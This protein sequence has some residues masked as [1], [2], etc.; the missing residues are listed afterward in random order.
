MSLVLGFFRSRFGELAEALG[1]LSRLPLGRFAP[2]APPSARV[3]W[4]FPLVGVILGGLAGGVDLL[5]A[6]LGLSPWLAAAWA[7]AVG[8]LLSGALHEDG[9]ADAADGLGAEGSAARRLAVMR[10]PRA[11]NYAVL[12]LILSV[13]IRLAALAAITPAGAA[14]KALMVAG[15]GGRTAMI[16][17]PLLLPP[18]RASGLGAALG[19]PGKGVALA[20]FARGLGLLATLLSPARLCAVVLAAGLGLGVVALA[21]KWRLGG[22]TGDI[23]GAVEQ[24]A[25]C[26]TLT[27][28]AAAG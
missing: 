16:G 18:A 19:T 2:S 9:L 1:L 3:M 12:A 15:I 27:V 7:V 22:Y 21:A 17:L 23:Y 25:E 14:A 26:L 28:L 6:R 10:D 24:V 8:M 5:A 20:A 13:A 4:A 11:G